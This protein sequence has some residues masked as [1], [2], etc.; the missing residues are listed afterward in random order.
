MVFQINNIILNEALKVLNKVVP[1]RS[2][3][4]ILSTVL[5]ASDGG[6]LSVRSTNLEVSIEFLLNSSISEPVNIAIPISKIFSI[7]SSLREETLTF[8]I[9]ENYK[10]NIKTEFGF[11]FDDWSDTAWRPTRQLSSQISNEDTK[12]L[13]YKQFQTYSSK[14]GTF[15]P[16]KNY[17]F[18]EVDY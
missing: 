7:T 10:I 12:T 16:Y 14:M 2:T 13:N 18:G 6:K 11:E 8:T 3:L 15:D 4:P 1:L 5:F 9:S 17:F